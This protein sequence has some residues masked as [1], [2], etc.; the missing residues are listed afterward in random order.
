MLAIGY[1][2]NYGSWLVLKSSE[3]FGMKVSESDNFLQLLE[4]LEV[5]TASQEN[6]CGKALLRCLIYRSLLAFSVLTHETTSD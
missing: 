2:L 5:G 3:L 4:D 6:A 1:Q